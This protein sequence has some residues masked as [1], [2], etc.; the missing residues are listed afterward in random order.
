MGEMRRAGDGVSR[1]RRR[2]G[3]LRRFRQGEEGW[4]GKWRGGMPRGVKGGTAGA[5]WDSESAENARPFRASPAY[6]FPR[7]DGER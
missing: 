6:G 7:E 2:E 1:P 3:A 5:E 4:G